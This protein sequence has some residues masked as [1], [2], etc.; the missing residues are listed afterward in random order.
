MPP[1]VAIEALSGAD[2]TVMVCAYNAAE[3][4][5]ATLASIASQTVAPGVVVVVDDASTDD[6][7]AVARAWGDRL[8]IHLVELAT[9][10]GHPHARVVAQQHC[11]TAL[12]APLDA[13]DLWLPDHVETMLE[14]YKESP[15]IVAARELLWIRD[16]GLSA[17][18]GPERHVPPAR[19]QLRAI[20]RADFIPIGTL[21]SRADLE[22]VGGFRE[23]MPEDWDLWIRMLRNGTRV[24]RAGHPTYVYRIHPTSSSFGENYAGHNVTT[25]ER[26]LTEAATPPERRYARAGLRRARAQ[27]HLTSSYRAAHD[28]D[29]RAARTHAWRALRGTRRTFVRG[30]FMLLAPRRGAAIHDQRLHDLESWIDR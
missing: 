29:L 3:T 22:A 25:L 24:T 2:V 9:N 10:G 26:A 23:V 17:A 13:D 21:F 6:T 27:Q 30:G 8:P 20:L 1:D 15:G 11:A 16:T 18:T 12:V 28:G 7:V 4:L 19:R 14:T 5:P